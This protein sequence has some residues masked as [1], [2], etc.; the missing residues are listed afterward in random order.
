[1]NPVPEPTAS[2]SLLEAFLSPPAE[3]LMLPQALPCFS[4][5]QNQ[6]QVVADGDFNLGFF[7]TFTS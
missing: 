4:V 7:L 5:V 3:F 6:G 2:A 1:M